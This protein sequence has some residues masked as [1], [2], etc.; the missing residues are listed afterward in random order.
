M[1][2][3]GE[4]NTHRILV[5]PH[6]QSKVVISQHLLLVASGL[7]ESVSHRLTGVAEAILNGT[8]DTLALIGSLVA[9]RAC[10]I[11]KLL[12]CGLLALRLNGTSNTV[13]SSGECLA[14]LIEGGLLAVRSDLLL[15]LLAETLAESVRHG[16]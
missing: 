9:S 5:H 2:K 8:K 11:T 4:F 6:P 16:G 13:A 1:K 7:V 10:G 15:R 3:L 12:S 14:G